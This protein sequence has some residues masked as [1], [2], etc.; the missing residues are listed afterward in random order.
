MLKRT[1]ILSGSGRAKTLKVSTPEWGGEK[2]HVFVRVLTADQ[3][4]V[5]NK[6]VKKASGG[7]ESDASLLVL[8]CILGVC[9]AKGKPLFKDD[10]HGKL[11]KEPLGAV[12]RCAMA[13]IKVNHLIEETDEERKKN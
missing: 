13:F 4:P 2:A 7:K 6:V 9:D 10:D 5:V 8:W 11:M 12:N 1:D 3:L